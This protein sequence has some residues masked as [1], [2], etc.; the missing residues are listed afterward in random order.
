[1][2]GRVRARNVVRAGHVGRVSGA[3]SP[4][5]QAVATGA[6]RG[7]YQPA[8]RLAPRVGFAYAPF[9]ND[10]TSIRGGFG[11][12]YDNAE[13]NVV[14]SQLNVPPF[15]NTPQ[16]ENG[17]LANPSGGTPSA[18]APFGTINAIYTNLPLA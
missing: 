5:L 10:K 8:N 15:I 13:G 2:C 14:F 1:C 12:F 17:N 18:L 4:V 9:G 3:T 7:F 16:F 6:P 11:I